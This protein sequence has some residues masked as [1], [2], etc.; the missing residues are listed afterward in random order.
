[1]LGLERELASPQRN[2]LTVLSWDVLY[3]VLLRVRIADIIAL[4][5]VSC[6]TRRLSHTPCRPDL[7]RSRLSS[8]TDLPTP[9]RRVSVQSA[10]D[11]PL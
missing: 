4:R 9:S 11:T 10:L 7:Y 3:Y 5:L 1:M 8:C 2:S 6:R